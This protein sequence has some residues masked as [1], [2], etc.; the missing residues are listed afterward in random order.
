MRIEREPIEFDETDI[1]KETIKDLA[2]ED[3]LLG[4]LI[5]D[6]VPY[7]DGVE[8]LQNYEIDHITDLLVKEV[9]AMLYEFANTI[10]K[11]KVEKYRYDKYN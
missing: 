4:E 2:V 3:H 11:E 7:A 6:K 8:K 1:I 5:S 10:T 9:S